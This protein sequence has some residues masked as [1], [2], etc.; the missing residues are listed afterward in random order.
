MSR[1][2]SRA[3][4]YEK[5]FEAFNT[6]N[7][8][9]F[10]F[11]TVKQSLL[12][13]VRI[14]FPEDFNDYIESSEFVAVLEIFA[15]ISELIAYRLDLNAHENLL[16]AAQRKESILRLAKLISYKPSRNVPARGLVRLSSITT[17][18]NIIDSNGRN[19][20]N[21]RIIWSDPNNLDWKEQFLLIMNRVLEQPFGTVSPSERAQIDDVLFELY[22]FKNNPLSINGPTVFSYSA[23]V[24]GESFPLE[25][26]PS[27]LVKIF[28]RTEI[29]EKRPEV[30]VPFTLLYGSD[31]LG[32][33]SPTTGF[34]CFSK[35]G[36]LQRQIATFDGV[37]P[38]QV[39]TI[40]VENINETDIFVN[41]VD[42]NTQAII[43]TD[44]SDPASSLDVGELGRFGEWVEV[45]LAHA[46]NIIFNTNAN[47]HKYE[48]EPLDLDRVRIIFG[49][50]EFA[51]IPSGTFNVWFRTSLN[52]DIVIP[53]NSIVEKTATFT[54]LDNDNNVQTLTFTFSAISSFLNNSASEDIEHIRRTAPAVY[55]TQ[56]RMVNGRDYNTFM[57]QDPTILKLRALNRTFAGDSKYIAWH[58]PRENY[59]N[60]KIFGDDLAL[61]FEERR[62]DDGT[63]IL[64]NTAVSANELIE[65]FIEPL[66]S[67]MDFFVALSPIF[68]ALNQE[69]TQLRRIFNNDPLSF[70]P[71]RQEVAEIANA[72]SAPGVS[73]VDLYYSVKYDEWTVN[74]H[75][76]DV[77][78]GP[79]H[80]FFGNFTGVAESIHMI[81]IIAR[82]SGPTLSGWEIR[83]RS[84]RVVAHSENTRFWNTNN[85]ERVI[86]FNSLNAVFDRIVLLQ[87]N[88]NSDLTGIL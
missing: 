35:Q 8:N 27:T 58:E 7:F 29:Q 57:L 54:Y 81:R 10:D 2:V 17:T 34:F 32:D 44:P 40:N 61:Y 11:N 84:K 33:S 69:P 19:L 65:D 36:T 45:D 72:L 82:Y 12:D 14:Y 71:A 47:R 78:P 43:A 18:E 85:A 68:Q 3:E 23:S 28:D 5:V 49:D 83:H 22:A 70:D 73:V 46:Q 53:Q 9:A 6:V 37:T 77:D 48:V 31:G 74:P 62:P 52:R 86:D 51:D 66:L 64:V 88:I 15:Y 55:Y 13:Y 16:S 60:V 25:L 50:D 79:S 20:T 67:S 4:S 76:F 87:A 42:P 63:L 21:R 26:V 38:N 75:Q 56:D 41:N 1:I 59:D 39:L 24:S 80:P 30:N